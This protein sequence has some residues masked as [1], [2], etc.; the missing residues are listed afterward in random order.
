MVGILVLFLVA[1]SAFSTFVDAGVSE[2]C[3]SGMNPP[4]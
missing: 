2:G 3:V 4:P 1:V